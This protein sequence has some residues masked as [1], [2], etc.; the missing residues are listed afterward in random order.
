MSAQ[1]SASFAE[2]KARIDLADVFRRDG[3]E[4]RR[5]GSKWFCVCPFHD[6]K[7]GSCVV[8]AE[9]FHCFGCG[10]K[11]DVFDYLQQR[12]GCDRKEAARRGA[13]LANMSPQPVCGITPRERASVAALYQLTD[14]ELT[15][16]TNAAEKLLRNPQLIERIAKHRGW[17]AETIRNIALEPSIGYHDDKLAFLYD[18]GVKL[19]WRENGERNFK[20]EFGKAQ[21]LWRQTY[22][23]GTTRTV[24]VCEGE[25]DCISMLDAGI[26]ADE[27]S[28]VV[29]LPGATIIRR[30]WADLFKGKHA[31]LCFDNDKAGQEAVAKF[32]AVIAGTAAKI[33]RL[34]WEK[35]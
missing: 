17:K 18:T 28:A 7:S 3:H 31:I 6:E 15:L 23:I 30:E 8:D 16:A 22:I 5:K 20:F 1:T 24:Y 11:G 4:L 2:I 21:S 26:E 13:E 14:A 33:S 9:R 19:R 32:A 35:K 12:H 10:A 25:T 29:A 34:N 27:T